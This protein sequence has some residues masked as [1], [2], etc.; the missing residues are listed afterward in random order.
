M[1][2]LLVTIGYNV[3]GA[4]ARLLESACQDCR[5]ELVFLIIS[6]TQIPE[7]VD[8]LDKLGERPDVVY[9]RYGVNRGLA[10]SWNEGILWG[11]EQHFDATLVVNEDVVLAPGDV[12]RLAT[13]AVHHR[14]APLAMGR[15]YHHSEQRWAWSEYGCFV[16]NPLLLETLGCFDEN[17]FP[18]YCEDSDFRRRLKLAGLSPAFCEE[19]RIIHGGSRSLAQPAV[20]RQNSLTYARNRQYYQRKWGGEA[21][22]ESHSQPFGDPRF[23][24]YIA[25]A[26]REV[27]YPGFNRN[28]QAIVQI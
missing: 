10:K 11:L 19:T 8:E 17:F 15:A 26:A 7:K 22:T 16:V 6:H 9:R 14:D 4:T 21:G 28:D 12:D 2:V 18:I 25:P 5:N 23:T 24:Y 1:R 3:P 20:A 27:P 13:T